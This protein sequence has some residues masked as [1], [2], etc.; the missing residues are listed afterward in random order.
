GHADV[1]D[2]HADLFGVVGLEEFLG[3][4]EGP[5]AIA[6]GFKQPAQRIA[7]GLVVV[8]NENRARCLGV[9]HACSW[10]SSCVSEVSSCGAQGKVKR[11]MVPPSG[12]CSAHRRP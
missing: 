7:Y 9:R 5:N 8:H 12:F 11:K 2:Q 4:T 10:M 1:D 6:V 3:A